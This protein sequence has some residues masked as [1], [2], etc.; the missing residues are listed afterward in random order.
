MINCEVD[1]EKCMI[2]RNVKIGHMRG[3]SLLLALLLLL[4]E[5]FRET[6]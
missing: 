5:L 3:Q 1:V 4:K 2:K 6:P